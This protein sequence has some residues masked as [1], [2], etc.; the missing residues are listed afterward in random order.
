LKDE[1]EAAKKGL[2]TPDD[3]ANR[4]MTR[5]EFLQ[6]SEKSLV[7]MREAVAKMEKARA[8]AASVSAAPAVDATVTIVPD[9]TH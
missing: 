9:A 4:P 1:R 7:Q 5:E 6:G 2:N 3:D 8:E